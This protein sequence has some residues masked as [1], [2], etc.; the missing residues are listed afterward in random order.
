V[1]FKTDTLIFKATSNGREREAPMGRRLDLQSAIHEH[2]QA[3]R[4]D[5]LEIDVIEAARR[6]STAV[7]PCG[8]LID[9]I[10]DLVTKAAEEAGV[11]IRRRLAAFAGS[12]PDR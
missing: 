3:H 12:A 7:G 6:I 9:Q 11:P 1:F 10:E 4:R 2:V 8:L 5:G